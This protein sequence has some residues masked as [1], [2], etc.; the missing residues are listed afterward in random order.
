M[1]ISCTLLRGRLSSSSLFQTCHMMGSKSALLN[2]QLPLISVNRAKVTAP[3]PRE[4]LP[5]TGRSA[6]QQTEKGK[7]YD[8]K[9]F[10]FTCIEGKSY[11]WCSCGWSKTQPFCDSSHKNPHLRLTMKPVRFISPETKE[12]TFC[13]C[14]QTNKR[15]FCDGTHMKESIQAAIKS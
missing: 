11:F 8:K 13:N 3:D 9:P 6:A 15:P 10:K 2:A 4:D 14:K 12:Y 1:T 5:K 7:I